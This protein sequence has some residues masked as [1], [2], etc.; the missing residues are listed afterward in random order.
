MLIETVFEELPL[1]SMFAFRADHRLGETQPDPEREN[2]PS[3]KRRPTWPRIREGRR[4]TQFCNESS[5]IC[6]R[7]QPNQQP[8]ESLR[9]RRRPCATLAFPL[10]AH[11]KGWRA[12]DFA[13]QGEVPMRDPACTDME[14]LA[15]WS[16]GDE[17]PHRLAR[18]Q[19]RG[20]VSGY[21]SSLKSRQHITSDV[22]ERRCVLQCGTQPFGQLHSGGTNERLVAIKDV[23]RLIDGDYPNLID[24]G[25]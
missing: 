20:N 16:S 11:N 8:G 21:Y 18:G 9:R 7:Q 13:N 10:R 23:A 15:N 5:I 17:A 24:A 2:D 14:P 4:R 1:S 25:Q 3:V 6:D 12:A 19:M 22:L